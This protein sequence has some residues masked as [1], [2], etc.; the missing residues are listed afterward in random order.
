MSKRIAFN[1]A[2]DFREGNQLDYDLTDDQY[3]MFVRIVTPAFEAAGEAMDV[4]VVCS[5]YGVDALYADIIATDWAGDRDAYRDAWQAIHDT[6]D[7]SEVL[8][9]ANNRIMA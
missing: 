1:L 2:A 3:E 7:L 9:A 5:A 6:A 4:E 8:V